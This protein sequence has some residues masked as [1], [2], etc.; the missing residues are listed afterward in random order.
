MESGRLTDRASSLQANGRR[1]TDNFKAVLSSSLGVAS[2]A[3]YDVVK[4]DAL[5]YREE[6]EHCMYRRKAKRGKKAHGEVA[7]AT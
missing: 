5:R 6:G 2:S 3:L 4:T 1:S 7:E